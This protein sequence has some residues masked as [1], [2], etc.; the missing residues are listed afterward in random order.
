VNNVKLTIAYE[1][2]H[3]LG[4]QKTKMGPSIEESLEKALATLGYRDVVLQAASRTDA[5]VHA[6]G[7]VINFFATEAP[8]LRK[9]CNGLNAL[10]PEGI[11]VLNAECAESDFHPTLHVSGKQYHYHLCLDPVQ[12]PFH[13]HTS[14]HFPATLCLNS[15]QQA[16]EMLIGTHD[17]SSF[18]NERSL[19]K[20]DAVR[21]LH[22]IAIDPLPNNRL[23]MAVSGN[24]FVYKMVRNIVGTLVYIGCGKLSVSEMPQILSS[25]DRRCAGTTAP[26]H[27]LCLQKV[28]YGAQ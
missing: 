22:A 21:T 25:K 28:F 27:G 5:G 18:C 16:A 4:W 10:L 13:R 11:S 20:N 19:L 6:N 23:R 2:T 26:A 7:Q 12:Y 8:N 1:G 9:L 17:F 14:W 3:F 15:M 24:H